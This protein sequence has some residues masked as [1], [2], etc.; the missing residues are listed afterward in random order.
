MMLTTG[1]N[2][3]RT[4]ADDGPIWLIPAKKQPIATTVET[5]ARPRTGHHPVGA[6]SNRSSPVTPPSKP[7]AAAPNRHTYALVASGDTDEETRLPK[8]T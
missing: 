2:L 1:S 7:V 4:A 3:L 8:T 5:I 6:K